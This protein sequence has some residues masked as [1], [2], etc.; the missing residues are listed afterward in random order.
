MKLVIAL[1]LVMTVR[2]ASAQTGL[3]NAEALRAIYQDYDPVTET[4]DGK[5]WHGNDVEVK[6][7]RV[8]VVLSV[9]VN[10]DAQG[11]R[12]YVV[13]SAVPQR[14][15]KEEYECQACAP[16]IGVGIFHFSKGSWLAESISPSVD[17]AGAWGDPPDADLVRIGA[18]LYGIRLTVDDMHQGDATT[19]SE[20]LAASGKSVSV[21]WKIMEYENNAGNYDPTGHDGNP[22]RI[23]FRS[24]Y[25]FIPS[26]PESD[27]YQ[28]EV[29]SRGWGYGLEESFRSQNWNATYRFKDG[30]Y[31]LV[32]RTEFRDVP[33]T[34]ANLKR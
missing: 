2:L 32:K 3:T 9:Q 15:P 27:H 28:I 21:I 22:D 4:A 17:S 34:K 5:L 20:L 10:S 6:R 13:T 8:D 19:F 31:Q 25:R 26:T 18:N 12:A 33:L 7:I 11:P 14:P 29:V 1:L 24:V 16:D 30:K 23:D